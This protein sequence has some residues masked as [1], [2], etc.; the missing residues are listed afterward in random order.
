VKRLREFLATLALLVS[1]SRTCL[2]QTAPDS[3]GA[4]PPDTAELAGCCAHES[5]PARWA[6][7]SADYLLYRVKDGPLPGPLVTTSSNPADV[8]A[9]GAPTT[10]VLFGDAD[11]D[12]GTFSG[13]RTS[14]GAWLESSQTVGIEAGGFLLEQRSLGFAVRSDAAG[15][16]LLAIPAFDPTTQTMGPFVTLPPG[17]TPP[18]EAGLFITQPG[19]FAGGIAATSASRLWDAELN[20]IANLVR[21]PRCRVDFLAG[22]RYLDL[23]ESL[24]ITTDSLGLAGSGSFA[25]AFFT[26]ADHFETRSQ[27]YGGQVGTRLELN[28]RRLSGSLLAKLALGSVHDVVERGGLTIIRN[29][30]DPAT[31]SGTFAGGLL[32]LPTNIG[33][34]TEEH[35]AVV[36]E[37]QAQLAY[38]WSSGLRTFVGYDFVWVSSV[39]RPG[40]QIDRAVNLTQVPA[41]GGS[42][43]SGPA[44]PAPLF[45][46]TDFWAHGV[47]FGVEFRY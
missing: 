47:R 3:P 21:C 37:V 4:I 12:Y 43:L 14:L 27:F 9:L 15:T 32:A 18:A 38:A 6:W 29:S 13:L 24:T 39:V 44:R 31:P 23:A 35:F 7:A 20:G 36:P 40:D 26:T 41:F 42:G 19:S 33:R 46:T 2:G 1:L 8:G 22:F 16:P 10:R 11:L 5:E 25:G 17:V 30:Q 34:Q 28:R 45:E